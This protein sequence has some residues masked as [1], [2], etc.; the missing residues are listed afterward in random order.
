MTAIGAIRLR[1]RIQCT[2]EAQNVP[3][4]TLIAMFGSSYRDTGRIK[5]SKAP[6]ASNMKN[7][8]Q[9]RA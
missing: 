8:S 3:N 9:T 7:L 6:D 5:Y 1:F 2:F 4:N